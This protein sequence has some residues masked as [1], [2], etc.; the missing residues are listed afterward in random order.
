MQNATSTQ[1][2]K[3]PTVEV[4]GAAP[5]SVEQIQAESLAKSTALAT[6]QD[7]VAG[8]VADPVQAG[9]VAYRATLAE[10][11][12]AAFY[13]R[14]G[15]SLARNAARKTARAEIMALLTGKAS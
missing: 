13:T 10:C 6:E 3:V 14:T 8:P 7:T 4:K 15:K 9:A 11:H 12:S 5:K 1:S 2:S